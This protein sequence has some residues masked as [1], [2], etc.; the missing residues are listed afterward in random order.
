[1]LTSHSDYMPLHRPLTE[2]I[3]ALAAFLMS[4]C[5]FINVLS[6]KNW[7]PSYFRK[8]GILASS[9]LS[10]LVRDNQFE[11]DESERKK[12]RSRPIQHTRKQ[13]KHKN[14]ILSVILRIGPAP[15]EL[16][17]SQVQQRIFKLRNLVYPLKYPQFREQ[18]QNLLRKELIARNGNALQAVNREAI[19]EMLRTDDY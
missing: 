19:Q 14:L 6:H 7:N 10:L 8:R 9:S 16:I 11:Q 13:I 17:F 2:K 18:L 5:T 1:M 3:S 4:I 15:A 12:A